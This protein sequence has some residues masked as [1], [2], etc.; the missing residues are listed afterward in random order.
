MIN[1]RALADAGRWSRLDWEHI[2]VE[3]LTEF[4]DRLR[5]AVPMTKEENGMGVTERHIWP[6]ETHD[7]H[8][9]SAAFILQL[10]ELEATVNGGPL[11]ASEQWANLQNDVQELLHNALSLGE[12]TKEVKSLSKA[13][14]VANAP[15][16]IKQIELVTRTMV[17][18]CS[19]E[20]EARW[21]REAQLK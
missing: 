21:F 13:F 7:A 17:H 5:R 4:L 15:Q 3:D 9:K 1:W 14:H 10:G 8:L 19:D 2:P 20:Y 6:D 11:E 16:Q 18:E 12:V